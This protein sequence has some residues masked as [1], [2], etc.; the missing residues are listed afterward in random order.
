MTLH[1]VDVTVTVETSA[2]DVGD[3][4]SAATQVVAGATR[5]I[6][7]PSKLVSLT[8]ADPDDQKAILR[9]VFFSAN[10]NLGTKDA[11]PDVDDT[12]LLT[13]I[14]HVDIAVADYVDYGGGSVA[15]IKNIGLMMKPAA[16]TSSVYMS[17]YTPATSTPTYA[18]GALTVRLG[19]ES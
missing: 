5:G 7:T 16:E 9:V 12:E 4:A 10:T 2:L 3:V 15:S 14:G 13:I 19:F 17:I 8:L 11:A 1:F 6:N 18:G